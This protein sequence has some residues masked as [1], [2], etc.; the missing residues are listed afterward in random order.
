MT[1]LSLYTPL[2]DPD[3]ATTMMLEIIRCDIDL[4]K[5]ISLD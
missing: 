4:G 1:V 3:H 5:L 2:T